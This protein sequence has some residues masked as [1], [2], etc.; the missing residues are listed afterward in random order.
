MDKVR[1]NLNIGRQIQRLLSSF[2][3]YDRLTVY[4]LFSLL[5]PIKDLHYRFSTWSVA[6][7]A[8]AQNN[9][10]TIL[11]TYNLNERFDRVQRR[12]YITNNSL[13]AVAPP[14]YHFTVSIPQGVD[15]DQVNRYVNKYILV[16]RTFNT[17]LI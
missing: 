13:N 3:K 9:S 8:E 12:I 7:R 4:W 16:D 6:Q 11:L 5:A 10:Q 1:Y 14:Q 17:I 15:P 2:D